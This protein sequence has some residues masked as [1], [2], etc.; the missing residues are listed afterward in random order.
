MRNDLSSRSSRWRL[1]RTG[2]LGELR[3]DFQMRTGK[4]AVVDRASAYSAQLY[5]RQTLLEA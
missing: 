2:T 1:P 3:G 5:R 4:K